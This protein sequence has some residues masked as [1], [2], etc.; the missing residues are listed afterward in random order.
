MFSMASSQPAP[1][2]VYQSPESTLPSPLGS[3]TDVHDVNMIEY[4]YNSTV[5]GKNT[6]WPYDWPLVGFSPV[7]SPPQSP[8]QFQS[9][10]EV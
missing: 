3:L 8:T 2:E 10:V 5:G 4:K 6:T 7:A 9:I 1:S